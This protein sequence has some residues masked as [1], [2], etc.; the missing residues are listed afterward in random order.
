[1]NHEIISI[2]KKRGTNIATCKWDKVTELDHHLTDLV[3]DERNYEKFTTPVCAFIT[4][5]SDDGQIEALTYSKQHHWYD[6][7]DRYNPY[8]GFT[9]EKI[10]GEPAHFIA[11]TEP[12][13]IQWENRHIKGINYGGRV[14]AAC[15]IVLMMLTLSFIAIVSFK[16]TAIDA[17]K[18]F[19]HVNATMVEEIFPG[20]KTIHYYEA[21]VNKEEEIPSL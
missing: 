4:F 1:M 18:I 11:A 12:T 3:K 7:R 8:K 19:G 5:E 13:N 16:K 17:E 20:T 2:L 10:L 14:A 15:L 21:G 6:L 9:K